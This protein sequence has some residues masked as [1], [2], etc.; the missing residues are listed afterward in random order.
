M[1]AVVGLTLVM[2]SGPPSVLPN[3]SDIF[4]TIILGCFCG[5]NYFKQLFWVVFVEIII[6]VV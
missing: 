5:D 6:K 4:Q 1:M 3:I 2:P